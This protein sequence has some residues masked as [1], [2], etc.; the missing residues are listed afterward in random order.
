MIYC[1]YFGVFMQT[2]GWFS[3]FLFTAN[4]NTNFKVFAF[5]PFIANR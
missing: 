2:Q 5:S 1:R 3:D 4:V